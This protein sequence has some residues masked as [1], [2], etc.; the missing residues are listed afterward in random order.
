MTFAVQTAAQVA[1]RDRIASWVQGVPKA[2]ARGGGNVN[3]DCL[4]G[5]WG[6]LSAGDYDNSIRAL[7]PASLHDL[8][9]TRCTLRAGNTNQLVVFHSLLRHIENS[10]NYTLHWSISFPDNSLL[11]SN[12][13]VPLSI[14][15]TNA[16]SHARK[17]PPYAHMMLEIQLR[18]LQLRL[19]LGFFGEGLF[20]ACIEMLPKR[21]C[22][23]RALQ[24]E[25]ANG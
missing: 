6:S 5:S 17:P 4:F 8:A 22:G 1:G 25:S 9:F 2:R 12:L 3:W 16:L 18:R 19:L 13:Q 21:L 20:V 10:D 7:D 23:L 15:G 24:L 14:L 11:T